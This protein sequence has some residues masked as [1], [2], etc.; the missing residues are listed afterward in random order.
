MKTS[1]QTVFYASLLLVSLGLVVGS[2]EKEWPEAGETI[3]VRF[4]LQQAPYGEGESLT[5]SSASGIEE[6]ALS[7]VPLGDNLYLHASLEVVPPEPTRDALTF[8]SGTQIIVAAYKDSETT[9]TDIAVYEVSSG[10]SIAPHVSNPELSVPA[11]TYTFV[12]YAYDAVTSL[13]PLSEVTLSPANSN[14]EENFLWGKTA[15]PVVI[16]GG[17]PNTVSITMARRMSKVNVEVATS[18]EASNYYI[19]SIS[20]V[21]V[22]PGYTATMSIKGGTFS[23]P[24]FIAQ[25]VSFG[26]IPANSTVITSAS[27]LVF[28]N[29]ANETDTTT[30]TIG[31]ITINGIPLNNFNLK[32]VFKKRLALNCNYT[33]QLEIKKGVRWAGSNIYWDEVGQTLTFAPHGDRSKEKYQGVFFQWGS[34]VGIDPSRYNNAVAW[35]TGNTVYVPVYNAIT[36]SNSSWTAETN[37]L[38]N[39]IP[40]VSDNIAASD[41]ST[42]NL[43]GASTSANYVSQKG[44]I[45]RYLS[46]G[47]G[48]TGVV[49]GTYRMPTANETHYGDSRGSAYQTINP[50]SGNWLNAKPLVNG[51]WSRTTYSTYDWEDITSLIA[52]NAAGTYEDIPSGGNYSGYS[53]FP[54]S[55][56]RE[57]VGL[58]KHISEYGFYWSSSAY[59]MGPSAYYMRFSSGYVPATNNC[60]RKYGLSVRCVLQE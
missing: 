11:G 59:S 57:N 54:A 38:W 30:V 39:D 18:P 46:S 55:G 20:D 10:G 48:G 16:A 21:R 8:T 9:A 13:S 45:C 40:Y 34:L 53:R 26:S 32:A 24:N 31:S 19:T 1:K 5:R 56:Q 28:T 4:L 51:Y 52:N 44:D 23:D 15:T 27:R 17:N 49:S 22:G 2:C 25:Y 33:I 35:G 36:P 41:V 60:Y 58:L 14:N 37:Q 7:V 12:A 43:S 6:E 29:Q 3:P 50:S 47:T 42:D